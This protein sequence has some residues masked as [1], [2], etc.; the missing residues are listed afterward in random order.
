M[1]PSPR[2]RQRKESTTVPPFFRPGPN[3]IRIMGEDKEE[4]L[5]RDTLRV[6][7][8][9]KEILTVGVSEYCRSANIMEGVKKKNREKH[10]QDGGNLTKQSETFGLMHV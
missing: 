1:H 5:R 10:A 3:I 4:C 6:P 7:F 9:E 2:P 8:T